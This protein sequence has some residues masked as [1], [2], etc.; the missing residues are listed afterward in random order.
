MTPFSGAEANTKIVNFHWV[1]IR[2]CMSEL[3]DWTLLRSFLAVLRRGSLSA[4]ART[5]GLT[6]PTVG[7]HVDELETGLGVALF[8]RSP[9]GLIPT[10][11]ARSLQPHAEAMESAF[12]ALKRA[13][14]LG[15]DADRPRG[16]VRI[17][18]SEVMGTFV[19]P[20][21]L[22][23]L[24]VRYPEVK[25]ELVLNN[26]TDDMLRRDADIAVRMTRPKQDGLVARKL[27]IVGLGL[28][29]H[30][31]YT[32]RRGQPTALDDLTGHDIVGFDQDD[33]SARS[34]ASGKLP[35]SRDIFSFR[36]DSDIAQVMAVRAGLGI[37]MMQKAMAKD[38][39]TLVPILSAE[40]AIDLE[41]WLVVHQD[42][43]ETTAIRALFDGLADGLSRWLSGLP[44]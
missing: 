16:T 43:K 12:A 3:N 31:D 15:G 18:A 35:I 17:S 7:R 22:A 5:T 38:D 19:L 33:H 34:V 4:A 8:T 41:C 42:Q 27:G 44:A 2:I 30:R 10:D 20:P 28:F 25:L 39:P 6:Q 1:A 21:I 9:A 32:R 40:V 29:A 14:T 13:A 36:V 23:G 26:R 24:R 37:G 11:A